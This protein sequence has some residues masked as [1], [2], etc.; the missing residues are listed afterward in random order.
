MNISFADVV[1][2]TSTESDMCSNAR[3]FAKKLELRY[4]LSVHMVDER[5]TTFEA[6]QIDPE[7]AHEIAAKLIAETYLNSDFG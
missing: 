2:R 4:E 5:L 6:K 1:N 3:S 7:G